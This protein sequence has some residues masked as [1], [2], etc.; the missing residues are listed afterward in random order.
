MSM[1]LKKDLIEDI[2][3]LTPLQTA[4]L[5]TYREEKDNKQ[6]VQQV[7]I[8]VK[9]NL[10]IE[11]FETAWDLVAKNNEMLR[12]VFRWEKI[13]SPVQIVLKEKKLK[14]EYVDLLNNRNDQ[15]FRNHESEFTEKGIDISNEVLRIALIKLEE[16]EYT[17]ILLFHHIAFDGWSMGI[18][19]KQFTESYEGNG[20]GQDR[21]DQ[22]NRTTF[23]DYVK[24]M[25]KQE[26]DLQKEYW[27]QEL[28]GFDVKTSLPT[29]NVTINLENKMAECHYIFPESKANAI[30]SFV[31]K[32]N[33]TLATLSYTAWAILLS[34]YSSTDDVLF[35]TT[36]SG[37][38]ADL[39]GIE[40]I[41]GL[42]INTLP[43]RVRVNN[44][45]MISDIFD[46]VTKSLML[47]KENETIPLAE[48]K[49]V[50]ELDARSNLFDSIVVVQNYPL[51]KG[52]NN[53][54]NNLKYKLEAVYE[55]T[56]FEMVLVINDFSDELE[57]YITYNNN[58]YQQEAVERVLNHYCEIIQEILLLGTGKKVMEI[59]MLPEK[60]RH[61]IME[62][63]N[64]GSVEFPVA[65]SYQYLFEQQVN[66][67]PN[68][69][70]LSFEG[71][72]VTYTELNSRA[73]QL[74]SLLKDCGVQ[75]NQF[76]PIVSD[77][78]IEYIVAVI[79]VLKAGAAFVPLDI[80]QPLER[81]VEIIKEVRATLL[82][83]KNN[84]K[85]LVS[86]LSE[87][88]VGD[89]VYLDQVS[90]LQELQER[91]AIQNLETY[92]EQY[93]HEALMFIEDTVKEKANFS[94]LDLPVQKID[95]RVNQLVH[96]LKSR[97]ETFSC[98]HAML[99]LNEG[100]DRLTA[101]IALTRL[102]IP[103]TVFKRELIN[104]DKKQVMENKRVN[105]IITDNAFYDE[106]DEL[107][108]AN[109][110]LHTI[111]NL[112]K[113]KFEYKK[114]RELKEI[115]EFVAASSSDEVNDYGWVN[116]YNGER[117]S[118]DEM[119]QYINNLDQ[120]L[121]PYLKDSS[122]VLEIGCGH[123]L[124][125]Q[126][127]A[128]KV[129]SYLGTDLSETV[130]SKN[131]MKQR[132]IGDAKVE[133]RALPAIEIKSL[134]QKFDVIVCSS[135]IHFFQNTLYLEEVIHHSINLIEDEGIIYLDDM[136]NLRKKD[137]LVQST[138]SYKNANSSSKTKTEW[139]S[140]LFVDEEFFNYLQVKYPEITSW[141]KSNKLG[142]IENELL[143]YRYDV[144]IKI[145]RKKTNTTHDV[146]AKYRFSVE[147]LVKYSFEG[148]T[149]SSG[150]RNEQKNMRIGELFDHSSY[151]N[152]P[153][154]NISDINQSTDL[155]YVIYTSGTTGKPKGVMIEHV[156][157]IN[158][159][160]AKRAAIDIGEDSII[161][162]NASHCFDQS[163]WQFLGPLLFGGQ[164]VIYS[165]ELQLSTEA[166]LN[167]IKQDKITVLEVVPVYLSFM[168]EV[169]E[170]INMSLPAL[171]WIILSGEALKHSL[172]R[173][174]FDL[175]P[176]IPMIN[177][178]GATEVSDDFTHFIMRSLP[179]QVTIG[180]P[181][182]NINVVVVDQLMRLC[183]IGVR[184]EIC[185]SGIG[186]GPGYYKREETT[187]A[188]FVENPFVDLLLGDVLY[189]TGD[190]GRW[191]PNGDLEFFDR[192]D[193]QTK[194]RGYRV[195]LG[196]IES[197]LMNHP[198]LTEC[199]VLAGNYEVDGSNEKELC[200][201]YISERKISS[202][203]LKEFLSEI[204]PVYMVP[205]YFVQLDYM[206]LTD[207]GKINRRLL[208]IPT[209]HNNQSNDLDVI[210]DNETEA[211][212]S[213]IWSELLG[214]S[215]I[216]VLDNFFDLG[217]HSLKAAMLISRI[218]KK[219]KVEV[220]LRKVFDT[221]SIRELSSFIISQ[222][223]VDFKKIEAATQQDYYP[224][225]SSQRRLYVLNQLKNTNT[226]Y[227]I[228]Y[229]ME[230][231]GGID[232]DLLE[233]A[234]QQI[235][236]R[237][238]ILRTAI[239]WKDDELVQYVL[240]Q[241]KFQLE[242]V[243]IDCKS[244]IQK[245]ASEFI[246]PFDLS[247]PPLIRIGLATIGEGKHVILF[248]MHH[249]VTDGISMSIIINDFVKL[250]KGEKLS[251]LKLHYKDY[252]VWEAK[253]KN[254]IE[255][256]KQEDYWLEHLQG[257]LPVLALPTDF[258]RPAERTGQG[259]NY[260][261]II[262]SNKTNALNNMARDTNTTLFM[263]LLAGFNLLLSKYSNQKEIIVGT[264]VSGRND[265]DIE[266]VVGM[267]VNTLPLRNY[268][269]DEKK[270]LD[271]INEV[272]HGLIG[273]LENDFYH[274]EDLVDKLSVNRDLSRNPVF[275][276]FFTLQNFDET[277]IEVNGLKFSPYPLDF[278]HSKFDLSLHAL[279]KE[280]EISILFE[281]STDIFHHETIEQLS[282]CYLNVIGQM[283]SNPD[284]VIGD[285]Q[286][287]LP[288][289]ATQLA[290]ELNDT[291]KSSPSVSSIVELIEQRAERSPDKIAV[292]DEQRKICYRKLNEISN[293]KGR[294]LYQKG[295]RSNEI[296]GIILDPSVSSVT[297]ILGVLKAGGAF[298]PID[299][300]TPLKRIETIIKES[301]ISL[302]I[303]Q[304]P[305]HES[306][307]GSLVELINLEDESILTMD[308]TN[309]GNLHDWS[310]LIYTIFTSGS[311]GTPKGVM[312]ENRSIINYINW[313]N[314]Y[315]DISHNDKTVLLS[316]L[317][318][319]LGYTGFF[320]TLVQGGELH[321]FSQ[322]LYKEPKWI[323]EYIETNAITYL[324]LT[325]S[326][327]NIIVNAVRSS[328]NLSSLRWII[329]GGES[330]N[331]DDV[332]RM[333]CIN[334]DIS[335][336]NE[337]GPTE[338]TI[339]SSVYLIEKEHVDKFYKQPLIG[340]PI[341]NTAIYILDE[342]MKQVPLG[343]YGEIYITGNG[344]AR[345][346]I[347]NP[348]MNSL[349]FFK[350]PFEQYNE[351]QLYKTG[352][353]GK[354]LSDGNIFLA[355]R[356]DNQVKIRGYR[357]EP[358]E[359]ARVISRQLGL[360]HI[361]V[362]AFENALKGYELCAYYSSHQEVNVTLAR[363]KLL[364][365]LP[366]YMLPSFFIKLDRIPLN[367]N[368]K[369][370]SKLLPSPYNNTGSSQETEEIEGRGQSVLLQQMWR[371]ILGIN[372]IRMDD[373]F[374]DI[375][376][377][378]LKAVKLSMYIQNELHQE[379][380]LREIFLY[381]T[382]RELSE[383]LSSKTTVGNYYNIK[384]ANNRASYP[385]SSVQRR[386]FLLNEFNDNE[387]NYNMPTAMVIEGRLEYERLQTAINMLIG[388][389][390]ALRTRFKMENGEIVQVIE[391]SLRIKLE[392]VELGQAEINPYTRQFIKPFNLY[393]AP[394]LR[395]ALIRMDQEKY[396]L[397]LDMH[398]IISDG[399]S[400]DKLKE[401][402]M[403]AYSGVST[404]ACELQYKDF[405]VW[406]HEMIN[407]GQFNEFKYYWK[408]KLR[409]CSNSLPLPT[410]F[411]REKKVGNNSGKTV[412]HLERGL[413]NKIFEIA[414]KKKITKFTVF[415]AVF[416]V[417]LAK[418]MNHETVIVGSPIATRPHINLL[419]SIGCFTDTL[420]LINQVGGEQT[421]NDFLTKV[422]SNVIEALDHQPYPFEF[423]A[424]MFSSVATENRNPVFDTFFSYE[425]VT[426]RVLQ[427]DGLKVYPYELDFINSKFDLTLNV[428]EFNNDLNFSFEY[429]A[430]LYELQTIEMMKTDLIKVLQAICDNPDIQLDEIRLDEN[431]INDN[432]LNSE[433]EINFNF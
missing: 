120:K 277:L 206:P 374:F 263:I 9:G 170:M 225:T 399:L 267:F 217:G 356:S 403:Y 19:L 12:S 181:I 412:L 259:R 262:D 142:H 376:G 157:M 253:V 373:N 205:T 177:S 180:K 215:R 153:E 49:T 363:K 292:V 299:P 348:E 387:T 173:K 354:Y 179:E 148:V 249:I 328:D 124:V 82:I 52:L 370:E 76:I 311:T 394:L 325:P 13:E 185:A 136:L 343:V 330:I 377:D 241:I 109:Q 400:M 89:V 113:P 305:E 223:S 207:N 273:A 257:D 196:E 154:S 280:G 369:V 385:V 143:L 345:G 411:P 199:I 383:Y 58:S 164:S 111:I 100:L 353:I 224:V 393:S 367:L 16:D 335:I 333:Y 229:V 364:A 236:N 112:D 102:G 389:H 74:A 39:D 81:M 28:A 60:E 368:G 231:E 202:H 372:D 268:P 416:N 307:L 352:D 410:D 93:P 304:N 73:N 191:L 62:E 43:L 38:E 50:S 422:G 222:K 34:R 405:A 98:N 5:I 25:Q 105:I 171:K 161:A 66:R 51:D 125:M 424:D 357:V 426:H 361:I 418:Y 350:N 126:Q 71:E 183:P 135:V 297:S 190:I 92:L 320:S 79:A 254:E 286:L 139:D 208:P 150:I 168:L 432:P 301:K 137:L 392:Y 358:D 67:T 240:P 282:R 365:Y 35:G 245:R 15:L 296:V 351:S 65:F 234:F 83:S 391:D 61:L 178:Y 84:Y 201:Y 381:P 122:N 395:G 147:D 238:E 283:T 232:R 114:D 346:Y 144:L 214:R 97:C 274:F 203:V 266:S 264:A 70:A 413:T 430:D 63:F 152:A 318:F 382:I 4:L 211:E 366:N 29:D 375:S 197:K 428:I 195:E 275:D 165:N 246:K 77:R 117:F 186:V 290:R 138:I 26:F 187:K 314:E 248:D 332:K 406:Q 210:P 41:V 32:H 281:Y 18:L 59:N 298:L 40:E 315:C 17:M 417:L 337:Y 419:N 227:N 220:P 45:T 80:N 159:I 87:E 3:S 27:K 221:P 85:D 256:K 360:E 312:I 167:T 156:G 107:F 390:E 101:M 427:L 250:Y 99:F 1:K 228:P 252:A 75:R 272:K 24:W 336:M 119:E 287:L 36:V 285:I 184:G 398:H 404:P 33:I 289:D 344:V 258:P 309:L 78:C 371:S 396:L 397:L 151:A 269:K 384:K 176:N 155:A 134:N 48:I 295:V 319:D 133:F 239:I 288:R 129:K 414:E 166:F 106:L 115:W 131:T 276:T 2:F 322:E 7:N 379:I 303:T 69:I 279:E 146:S 141:E 218:S 235:I 193:N 96:L 31:K 110:L 6:Y 37:R 293:Q 251:P 140:D 172:A 255:Y 188:S 431:P 91:H 57:F 329:L 145:N 271:F 409:E 324:K 230:I 8:R 209:M 10:E 415:L 341:D 116:S 425:D 162:Q 433:Q 278:A 90:I 163:I 46:E 308:D 149:Y 182:P 95:Y 302:L 20:D 192:K 388:K 237:H 326:M 321:I 310:N 204:L 243:R 108:W 44:D 123:G 174:W 380:S 53:S 127:I 242:N 284:V 72:K 94:S 158:H 118:L 121:S 175:F 300:A 226:G 421:F 338:T 349:K 23:K 291:A 14:V 334:S 103:Y 55:V 401:E 216:S 198:D 362:V 355:G 219:F 21:I 47:R 213:S 200:A 30:A 342:Q 233:E 313:F 423:I 270:L 42:F 68:N 402:F 347:N 294:K 189:K 247:K 378:S 88:F 11:K 54:D 317:A 340:K 128:P 386:F 306:T 323:V 104:Q 327:F 420:V 194:I 331:V 169:L 244:D 56:N 64:K 22:R 260:R 160:Y 261:F 408:D 130:V 132:M 86:R 429:N 407:S 339:G 212:L 265:V 359:V 316:S